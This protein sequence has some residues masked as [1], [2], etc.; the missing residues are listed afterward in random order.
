[1]SQLHRRSVLMMAAAT[2]FAASRALAQP[3]G[4]IDEQGFVRI[5]G[6]DQWIAIQGRDAANPVILYLHGGPAEAQSPF[7]KEFLP[8]EQD[9]TVVNWDQRGSG[10]TYGKNG[11][12]TPDMTP[13]RMAL[14]AIEIA[15]H[16]SQ[17]LGK[18]KVILV[19]QS[20]GAILGVMTVRRR[21][22]LFHAFV[23]TAQPV[24][25]DTM[26]RDEARWARSQATAAGDQETLKALDD[27][28]KLPPNDI[29]RMFA[30]GK[31]RMSPTD[32]TYLKQVQGAFLGDL[33]NGVTGPAP[34]PKS[35]EVADWVAGGAFSFP[36]IV[37][38]LTPFD[39]RSAGEDFALPVVVIQ[40]RDDHVVS[41]DAAKAWVDELRA[42]R[43]GLRADRRRPF[44]LFHQ[45]RGL[46]RRPAPARPA[47][48]ARGLSVSLAR[49]PAPSPAR[50]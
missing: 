32:Q 45:S 31:Y 18:R 40:G 33:P 24:S 6:I 20:W 36:K 21:P 48:G 5:G 23:G 28:D 29:R 13:D 7:L 26:I 17:R 19:G 11:P 39:I 34:P 27:A 15:E 49:A 25:W 46:R 44:R 4:P 41:F 35:Q 8:W 3:K 50:A 14:D 16:V 43:Q 37:P 1:M 47:A 10:K 30:V 12:S 2:P 22:E 42:P 9:F 38:F